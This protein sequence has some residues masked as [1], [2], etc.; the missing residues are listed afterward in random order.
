MAASGGDA[1]L[2]ARVGAFKIVDV[3][4]MSRS[5][6]IAP[7]SDASFCL[8]LL[9]KSCC[10]CPRL[11]HCIYHSA[12]I[13]MFLGV[14]EDYEPRH[15]RPYVAHSANQLDALP[16]RELSLESA[17][18]SAE[19]SANVNSDKGKVAELRLEL[20][21]GGKKDKN[22]SAKK[23]ALKKI[24]ANMTMSN[25]D[26]V[27]LFPDVVGCMQIPSLEIKK[28]YA[29][30]S[31]RTSNQEAENLYRCFLFLVNYA[32]VKPDVAMKALPVLVLVS[33]TAQGA[34]CVRSDTSLPGYGGLQPTD[35]SARSPDYVVHSRPRIRRSDCPTF[36]RVA[37]RSR[38]LCAKDSRFLCSQALRSRQE[39][40]GSFRLD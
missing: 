24:V 6:S 32:R 16:L 28:M 40:R 26:M 23:V 22:H 7:A 20:N 29:Y 30:V 18:K 31:T 38:P 39:S 3:T 4:M 13:A 12:L 10:V 33:S 21:S 34:N 17:E 25:N 35:K 8:F 5:T 19:E 15:V 14:N 37:E 1:K 27:A 36:E 11:L 9:P 2:F